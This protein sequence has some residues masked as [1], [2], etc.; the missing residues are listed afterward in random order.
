MNGVC[1]SCGIPFVE[2]LGL[3]GTCKGLMEAKERMALLEEFHAAAMESCATLGAIDMTDRLS[4]AIEA[5]EG[6]T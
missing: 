4:R 5:M 2:H 6:A 3:I 1:E